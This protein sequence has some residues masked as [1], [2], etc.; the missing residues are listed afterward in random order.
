MIGEI[1]IKDLVTQ[2]ITIYTQ[3]NRHPVK[4]RAD[5]PIEINYKQGLRM[6]MLREL[7]AGGDQQVIIDKFKKKV[8]QL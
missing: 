6:L 4:K 7:Q 2:T 5:C 1:E 8:E 3:K